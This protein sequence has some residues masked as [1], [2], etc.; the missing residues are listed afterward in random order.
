[1]RGRWKIK[2]AWAAIC[3]AV[4]MAASPARSERMFPPEGWK[5]APDP[6]A[7]PFAVP[8]GEIAIFAGPY[9]KSL[10]YYLDTN[11]FS[12][13]IFGAM[14][15]TLLS[16]NSRTLEYEP[17]LA[18]RWSIS[19]DQKTFTFYIDPKAKWSDG[20]PVTA[21]DVKW[22][23]EAVTNPAHL[24]GPHKIDLERFHSPE[25]LD[26]R[27][28]RFTATDVHWKNLSAVGNFYIMPRHMFKD[29]DFNKINFEFP[30]VSGRYRLAKI[31]EGRFLNMERR[32]D[33]WNAG[34]LRFKGIG[35]FK[36]LK[37]RFY[38]EREN[39][40]DAFKKGLIDL[41]PV[42]TSRIWI[43]DVKGEK[44]EKN[45]IVKQSVHNH[46]P[47]GFQ[48]FAMNMRRPPF[49]D[50]RVRKAMAHLLN[51]RKMN[52]TLMYDQYFLHRSYFEDLW[53]KKRPCPNPVMEFDRA[54]ADALLKEAGWRASPKTGIL[55]KNGVPFSFRFLTRSA[56]V[57]KFL[58]IYAED[59]KNSGIDL[60]IDKKDWAA[61]ARDMDEFN[62]QM[63]WAAWS[64]GIFKDPEGM[65]LSG[66]ADRKGGNNITGFKSPKVD[67]LID[68]QKGV[69]H[70]EKRNDIN[71]RIDQEIY[72][73]HP[74]V[75]LWNIRHTRLL[76]WNKFG[77]PETV[78]SKYGDERSAYW[79]W[80]MDEDSRADL[81][82]AIENK[83][84]L[85]DR[86]SAVF[87]DDVF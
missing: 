32:G 22:T 40:F 15:E 5:D 17:S 47:V 21:F 28:I 54:K 56:F 55:E 3:L 66:E 57:D 4:L 58:A 84:F 48:G 27:T 63:T 81:N 86:P 29:K 23:W 60:V 44:F 2:G 68:A 50:V 61:W 72:R 6:V 9:P 78:L 59:L 24:T 76:H 64:S 10:N 36:T 83:A 43:Q 51:R 41:F 7:S 65:W 16:M 52:A 69:F 38:A 18:E 73:A 25:I 71:R 75:L 33:W 12:A 70:I 85:P 8:G 74:Y 14:Y 1:M 31:D 46:N 19:D 37:F 39:A 20:R 42:Y 79:L 62:Y 87:F 26:S 13:E 35:N 67:A 82:D 49:D 45:W 77:T 30:T 11:V 53:S 80:W 34:A